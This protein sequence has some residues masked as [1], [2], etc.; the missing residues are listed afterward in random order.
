MEAA[1]RKSH[2]QGKAAG[3]SKARES[4]GQL[5]DLPSRIAAIERHIEYNKEVQAGDDW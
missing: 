2:E 1:L 3:I 5:I 4:V